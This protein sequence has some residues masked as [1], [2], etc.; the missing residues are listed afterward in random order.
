MTYREFSL[1]LIVFALICVMFTS[2]TIFEK[3]NPVNPQ[4]FGEVTK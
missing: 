1:I 4:A 3:M 2:M